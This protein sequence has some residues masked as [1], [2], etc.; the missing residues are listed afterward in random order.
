MSIPKKIN[1]LILAGG[2]SVRMGHDK[3]LINY[4]GKPQREFLFELIS[5]V[6]DQVYTSCKPACDIPSY[7]NP[8]PDQLDIESPLNGIISALRTNGSVAWLTAPVDMPF[9]TQSTLTFLLDNRDEKKLATCFFDSDGKDPEPLLTLWEPQAYPLL[10]KHY[11]SGHKGVKPF[12]LQHDIHLLKVPDPQI[13]Q[14]VNSSLD[15][16]AY[17]RRKNADGKV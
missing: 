9:I 2:K 16:A 12:L 1:G 4:H 3:G 7:L 6:C 10:E 11:Q 17:F 5:T 15:L 14:N 13:H 8:L